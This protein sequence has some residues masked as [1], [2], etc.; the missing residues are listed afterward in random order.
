GPISITTSRFEKCKGPRRRDCSDVKLDLNNGIF[1]TYDI[2]VKSYIKLT[3]GRI[4]AVS[5]GKEIT[6][7][8]MKTPCDN[9][10][11]Q[12]M[13]K[14]H[15]NVSNECAVKKGHYVF[16][17]NLQDISQKYFDGNYFYGNWTFRTVF[18]GSECNFL[19]AVMELIISP[20]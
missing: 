15:L 11:V 4:V 20:K 14:I 12:T 7:Y 8:Q 3:T 10:L 5:N 9:F 19:C 18:A 1:I 16:K 2:L 17:L 13:F 6:R